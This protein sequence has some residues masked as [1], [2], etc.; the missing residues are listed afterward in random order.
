MFSKPIVKWVGGK[1]QL[2]P[3]LLER[4]PKKIET[5]FEPFLGGGA[6]FFALYNQKRFKHAWLNDSNPELTNMYLQVQVRVDELI[7]ELSTYPHDPTFYY[8]L[9]SKTGLNPLQ[10]AARF[11]YINR[12]GYNGLYRVNK[13]GACNTP[14]GK[15]KNPTICD[16]ELLRNAAVALKDVC[17]TCLDF[18]HAL[19]CAQ[20]GDFVYLDP[21]YLSDGS[22][23]SSYTS[24][25]F[26][27]ED[28]FRLASTFTQ[29]CSKEVSC[30]LSNADVPMAH[31]LYEGAS[32]EKV[33]A[34]RRV[35][36]KSER[37]TT[38]ILVRGQQWANI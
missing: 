33:V 14:F 20:K 6:L 28:H 5:Y 27:L 29:L 9:R 22:G 4:A 11:I 3:A 34:L 10:R 2:I 35:N 23:F 38:E 17:L 7:S 32:I 15:Y 13:K 21:P 25:G 30:L 8:D 19:A 37:Q 16:P 26:K 36:P 12:T 24:T 18:D 31:I 1:R